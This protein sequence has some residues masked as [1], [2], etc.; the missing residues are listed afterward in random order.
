M[1]AVE[2]EVSLWVEKSKLVDG[3]V[4][5]CLE[6]F[7]ANDLVGLG[8]IACVGTFLRVLALLSVS[9]H[10]CLVWLSAFLGLDLVRRFLIDGGLYFDTA[11]RNARV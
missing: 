11:L 10:S 7:L 4:G 5:A 8:E 9:A 6:E 1:L 2:V 3:V